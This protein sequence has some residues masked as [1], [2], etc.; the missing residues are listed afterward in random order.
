MSQIISDEDVEFL[1]N[2]TWH[3]FRS[4]NSYY[5]DVEEKADTLADYINEIDDNLRDIFDG[6]DDLDDFL[7]DAFNAFDL[8]IDDLAVKEKIDKVKLERKFK[9]I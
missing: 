8:D 9:R 6:A 5:W 3:K 7:A 2:D 1:L 4:I